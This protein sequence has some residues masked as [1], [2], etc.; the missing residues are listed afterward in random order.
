[1]GYDSRSEKLVVNP[2]GIAFG[3]LALWKYVPPVGWP[4]QMDGIGTW[5][6]VELK[7]H[8]GDATTT[9]E[10]QY[11][12]DRLRDRLE[13]ATY[14]AALRVNDRVE[15]QVI[16]YGKSICQDVMIG[17]DHDGLVATC[18][19]TKDGAAAGFVPD[20]SLVQP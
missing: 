7:P 5:N 1:M 19:V 10:Q 14:H 12:D 6:K 9:D 20:P 17:P 4:R 16:V 13:P 8:A 15:R 2:R 3:L 18:V 11:L